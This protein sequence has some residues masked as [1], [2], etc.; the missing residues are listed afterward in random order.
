MGHEVSGPDTARGCVVHVTHVTTQDPVVHVVLQ[1]ESI[2][3]FVD[4]STAMPYGMAY[5]AT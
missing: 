4:H 3:I 2:L 5:I 1:P